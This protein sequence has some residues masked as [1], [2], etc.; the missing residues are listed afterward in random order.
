VG[1]SA[2]IF[3]VVLRVIY[4]GKS[5]LSWKKEPG[6]INAYKISVGNSGSRAFGTLMRRWKDNP[7]TGL[8]QEWGGFM[9]F[10]T[11]CN[12]QLL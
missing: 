12:V 7:E 10:T 4:V 2:S 5:F 11:G 6:M 3:R 8:E 9:W 1:L